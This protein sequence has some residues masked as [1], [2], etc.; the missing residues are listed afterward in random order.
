ME[1]ENLIE[2]TRQSLIAQHGENSTTLIGGRTYKKINQYL[3]NFNEFVDVFNQYVEMLNIDL[4]SYDAALDKLFVFFENAEHDDIL[5]VT[6]YFKNLVARIQKGSANTGEK[7]LKKLFADIQNLDN[8]TFN[9]YRIKTLLHLDL[10]I[11]FKNDPNLSNHTIYR[12]G[13]RDLTTLSKLSL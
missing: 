13:K 11:L 4:S 12:S 8:K 1:N 9:Y 2:R 7:K 6:K 10:S 5:A 3:T